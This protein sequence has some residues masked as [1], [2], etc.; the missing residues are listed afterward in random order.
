MLR[1]Y[2]GDVATFSNF[3]CGFN[4]CRDIGNAMLRHQLDVTVMSRHCFEVS[5]G[6]ALVSLRCRYIEM[7]M[8]RH[9]SSVVHLLM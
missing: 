7:L 5:L 2:R 4:G 8:S 9:W 6:I 1:E 3:L